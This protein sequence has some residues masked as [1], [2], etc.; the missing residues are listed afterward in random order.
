[1]LINTLEPKAIE[2]IDF[3]RKNLSGKNVELLFSG[4]KDSI[5][6]WHLLREAGV[7]FLPVFNRTGLEPPELIEFVKKNYPGVK[8]TRPKRGLVQ[9]CLYEAT[10]PMSQYG[11]CCRHLKE[12]YTPAGTGVTGIRAEES[13]Q[14]AKR[15]RIESVRGVAFFHPIFYWL[16]WEVWE[17]IES[18]KIA[19]PDLYDDRS[20]I[21]CIGCPKAGAKSMQRD[22]NRWPGFRKV[23]KK[24]I[25]KLREKGKY[26][27][28]DSIDDVFEWWVSGMS[29]CEYFHKKNMIIEHKNR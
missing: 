12:Y 6:V 8:W 18:R 20:R 17:Y 23:F 22:F 24:A 27:D 19:F 25:E 16:E 7:D 13:A 10:L 28:F 1:M 21:G 26:S 11:S 3:L 14:R 9:S 5:V 29:K 15:K 4:G 2:T